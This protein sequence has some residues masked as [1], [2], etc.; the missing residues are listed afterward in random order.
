MP[1]LQASPADQNYASKADSA[2]V[3]VEPREGVLFDTIVQLD[4]L[5]E[6]IIRAWQAI[7]D[8]RAVLPAPQSLLRSWIESPSQVIS[9]LF[10]MEFEAADVE[11]PTP[12]RLALSSRARE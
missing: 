7:D 6:A 9:A 10:T 12:S 8:V 1:Q 11:S 4:A 5:H 2:L 3:P